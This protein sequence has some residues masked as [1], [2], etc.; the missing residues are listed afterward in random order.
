MSGA[1]YASWWLCPE[2]GWPV[3]DSVLVTFEDV[4][5]GKGGWVVEQAVAP[6]DQSVDF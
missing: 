4:L 6:A 1:S 3:C 2:A 5:F